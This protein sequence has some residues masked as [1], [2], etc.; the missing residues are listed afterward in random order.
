VIPAVERQA[1]RR[2]FSKLAAVQRISER[3]ARETASAEPSFVIEA[4]IADAVLSA[5]PG[6]RADAEGV[7]S[8]DVKLTHPAG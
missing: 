8:A 6:A 1:V 7:V 5:I 2:L 4:K 3:I